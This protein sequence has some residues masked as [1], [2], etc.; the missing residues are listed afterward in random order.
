M[1]T[2]IIADSGATE[3]FVNT[4]DIFE[5]LSSTGINV[6]KCANKTKLQ[7]LRLTG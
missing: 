5:Y 2:T 4:D 1:F 3:T 6:I 7:I